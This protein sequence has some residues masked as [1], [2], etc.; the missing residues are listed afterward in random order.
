MEKNLESTAGTDGSAQP[1]DMTG[2]GDH[3]LLHHRLEEL[4]QIRPDSIAL[5]R[6]ATHYT[7]AEFDGLANHVARLLIGGTTSREAPIAVW[8]REPA[9]QLILTFGI[10]KAGFAALVLDV[11]DKEP[12]LRWILDHAGV[13]AVVAD[14]ASAQ[15]ASL[16]GS[17]TPVFRIDIRDTATTAPERELAPDAPALIIYTS[18]SE[19]Q[20]KG[21]I[22]THRG[23][24]DVCRKTATR[25]EG[26]S[27][28]RVAQLNPLNFSSGMKQALTA[29][30]SGSRLCFY[31]VLSQ[32]LGP[33]YDWFRREGITIIPSPIAFFR[34][35]LQH[36]PDSDSLASC[37]CVVLGGERLFKRDVETF[38]RVFPDGCV[39]IYTYGSTECGGIAV[40]VIRD[41]TRVT[42]PVPVGAPEDG[43]EIRILSHGFRELRLKEVGLIAV[44]GS[45]LPPGYWKD[46]QATEQRYRPSPDG[47]GRRMCITGDVGRIDEDGLL[48]L[49][50]RSDKQLKVDGYRIDLSEIETALNSDE[51]VA[52]AVVM[53]T[54]DEAGQ[55]KVI[56]YVTLSS[57]SDD[58]QALTR[59]LRRATATKLPAYMMPDQFIVLDVIPTTLRGKIDRQALSALPLSP[60]R[61]GKEQALTATEQKVTEVWKRVFQREEVSLDDDILDLGVKS[62]PGMEMCLVL[63]KMFSIDVPYTQLTLSPTARQLAAFIESQLAKKAKNGVR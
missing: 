62:L 61:A 9:L 25:L 24:L 7:F 47:D 63:G 16:A 54:E 31:D 8:S 43:K 37:R 20:P 50:R 26:D 42:D 48:Y 22:R 41:D 4:A 2:I 44:L 32:G 49:Y 14:T 28:D 34:R 40:H 53:T 59:E 13:D 45:E 17:A 27:T 5:T 36:A 18:G 39:L 35:V 57:D 52:H 51:N 60:E 15:E 38:R 46:P 58:Q 33:L 12:R 1:P 56:A 10:W 21:V 11:R 23:M 19:G 29:V 55:S 3:E 6:N 30:L